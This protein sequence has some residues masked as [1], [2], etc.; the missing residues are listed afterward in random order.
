MGLLHWQCV[1]TDSFKFIVRECSLFM[2]NQNPLILPV[3]EYNKTG[4]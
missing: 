3:K 2:S 4:A 1:A